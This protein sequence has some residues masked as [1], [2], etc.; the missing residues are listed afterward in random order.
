[1]DAFVTVHQQG[2][3]HRD[4]RIEN[5]LL[6]SKSELKIADFGHAGL[7]RGGCVSHIPLTNIFHAHKF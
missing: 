2:V 1:V 7:F 3:C 5:L 6:D 4:L